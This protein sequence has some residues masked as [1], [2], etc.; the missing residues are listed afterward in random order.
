MMFCTPNGKTHAKL[1]AGEPYLVGS[2]TGEDVFPN[3]I[4]VWNSGCCPPTIGEKP[5]SWNAWLTRV[6]C[7]GSFIGARVV[8]LGAVTVSLWLMVWTGRRMAGHQ[9]SISWPAG[10]FQCESQLWQEQ[11]SCL[12]WL[13]ILS[14]GKC[15]YL[16]DLVAWV[17][18]NTVEAEAYL[19]FGTWTWV[20]FAVTTLS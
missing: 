8:F 15:S 17:P 16:L 18:D 20:E 19:D 4:S 9:E 11:L 13:Q 10:E 3:P 5:G 14:L 1:W 12:Y 7:R 2:W 6:E